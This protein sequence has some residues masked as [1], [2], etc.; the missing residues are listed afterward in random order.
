[1]VLAVLGVLVSIVSPQFSKIRENQ[2][3]KNALGEITS[4][5]DTAKSRSLASV[6]LSEY[7]V[8]FASDQIIIFKGT[9]YTPGSSNNEVIKIVSPAFI[10]NVTLAGVSASTGEVYFARLSGAPSKTGTVTVSLP[11]GSKV[12]TIATTGAV[13]VN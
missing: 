10:S 9:V 6:D 1:M 4:A 12:I 5:L 2:A 7:G 8:H 3:L 13:S 11:S